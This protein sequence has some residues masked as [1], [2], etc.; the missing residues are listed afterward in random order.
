M[1]IA[2]LALILALSPALSACGG[3]G[4]PGDLAAV[5]PE[6]GFIGR[7]LRVE[8]TGDTTDWDASTQVSFGAG[9][10]VGAVELVS[11]SALQVDITIDPTAAPGKQDV[12]VTTGGD[13]LTLAQAFELTAPTT[14][15]VELL[16][17]GGFGL[18]TINNLD[19]LHPFDITTNDD[20]DFVNLALTGGDA[21]GVS[22]SIVRATSNTLTLNALADVTA[23]ET[24]AFQITSTTDGV[25]TT[26]P[27]ASVAVTPRAPIALTL[28]TPSDFTVAPNGSLF[29][30][31]ATEVGMLHVDMTNDPDGVLPGFLV[32]PA[33]GK[34]SE[35]L[36][37]HINFNGAAALDNRVVAGN[38]KFYLVALEFFGAAGYGATMTSRSIPLTGIT[39][40]TDTGVNDA[41]NTAQ[42]LTGTV[43]RFDGTLA[44]AADR[45]CFKIAMAAN[46]RAHVYTTDE[47][48]ASDTMVEVYDG[49]LANSAVIK[50]SDD[51]DL[52][53][54][55]QTAVL[56]TAATRSICVSPSEFA[57]DGFTN[58]PYSAIVVIE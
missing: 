28:G 13:T 5:F 36:V 56:A 33:S 30:V 25:T 23:T 6:S 41:P 46:K 24:G 54:E 47:N 18:I 44:N 48:G 26:S 7:T 19:L 22:L 57:P 42:Q 53:E 38:E 29:E 45:D 2:S 31:S 20:G 52:G 27:V 50:A 16:E 1:R 11:P 35:A 39:A 17:Q 15:E 10:T 51:A 4:D 58:A 55:V 34:F 8:I 40:V 12:V 49:A 21:S 32:L 14:T 9:V 37:T 43:A 3:G